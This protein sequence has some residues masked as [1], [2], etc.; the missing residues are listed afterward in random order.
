MRRCLSN[1][2]WH[3]RG[4]RFHKYSRGRRSCWLISGQWQDAAS[5]TLPP[6]GA[7][8]L[9]CWFVAGSISLAIYLWSDKSTDWA[10]E[11]WV[12]SSS[13]ENTNSI[14]VVVSMPTKYRHCDKQE[15]S[16]RKQIARQLRTQYVDD[17][18]RSNYPVTLISRLKV[19]QG[20]CRRNHMDR[21]CTT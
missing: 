12:S 13:Q 15:L 1:I 21:S 20:H 17:I 10:A 9:T 14:A 11:L 16:Y 19:T 5:K 4:A 2:G 18:Y 3:T 8:T 7:V 6:A